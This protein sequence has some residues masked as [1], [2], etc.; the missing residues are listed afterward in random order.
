MI[1]AKLSLNATKRQLHAPKDY[2]DADPAI[3]EAVDFIISK[4]MLAVGDKEK[5]GTPVQ[6]IVKQRLVHDLPG[7]QSLLRSKRKGLR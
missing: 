7:F 1:P 6:R 4:K 3:K 5:P 2:Y